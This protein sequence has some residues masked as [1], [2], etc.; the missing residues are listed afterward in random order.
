MNWTEVTIGAV[1]VAGAGFLAT[2]K[3]AMLGVD[4]MSAAPQAGVVM[5][6]AAI[7]KTDLITIIGV[8]MTRADFVLMMIFTA[9]CSAV[10]AGVKFQD[11]R[12]ALLNWLLGI[13]FGWLWA[14]GVAIFPMVPDVAVFVLAPSFSLLS[15]RIARHFITDD[16]VVEMILGAIFRKRK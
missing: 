7:D 13:L 2:K 1:G 10:A 6:Q 3:M 4:A 14:L 9:V 16:S 11:W 12:S 5:M 8:S 15:A